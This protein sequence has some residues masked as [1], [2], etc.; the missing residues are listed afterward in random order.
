MGALKPRTLN[1]SDIYGYS[2]INVIYCILQAFLGEINNIIKYVKPSFIEYL[3]LQVNIQYG[4]NLTLKLRYI[5][6]PKTANKN[7]T[8]IFST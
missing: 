2:F 1:N 4:C 5:R 7:N 3:Q 6:L 8:L